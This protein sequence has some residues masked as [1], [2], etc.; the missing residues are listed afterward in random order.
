ML[1]CERLLGLQSVKGDVSVG[2]GELDGEHR[3]ENR[4]MEDSEKGKISKRIT[5]ITTL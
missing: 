4:Y 5:E 3:R 1:K 2:Q